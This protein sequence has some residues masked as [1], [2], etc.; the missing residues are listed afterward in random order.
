MS[1]LSNAMRSPADLAPAAERRFAA[2]HQGDVGGGAAHVEGDEVGRGAVL[3]QRH[4]RRDAARGAGKRGAGGEARGFLH[5]RDAAV[6]ED[7]E[8]RPL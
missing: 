8:E 7:D 6:A 2:G 4:G 3:R 5:G 1:R